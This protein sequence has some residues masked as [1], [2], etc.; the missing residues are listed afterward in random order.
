MNT[1]PARKGSALLIV[2]GMLSFMVVS[3]VA[4]SA[5]MRVA[6]LPSSYLRRTS[7]SRQ[8]VKAAVARAIDSVDRAIANNPH[9]GIGRDSIGGGNRNVW[10]HRIFT[11]T[12]AL[13]EADQTVPVLTLEALA[14]IPPPLVN[15]A[16]Y[17]SRKTPSAQWQSFGF[18]SGR[19]A[20][21]AIDV[22]DYFDVN[23][24][25][26]DSARSSASTRRVSLAY[27]FENGMDHAGTGT[28]AAQWDTFMETFRTVD[29]ETLE[30]K[31]GTKMPLVSVADLN[32]AIGQG[33]YGDL[34]SP[35]CKYV[36]GQG[37]AGFYNT[38]SE[39]DEDRIRRM[40]FVTDSWFPRN[41][42]AELKENDSE[43]AELLDLNAEDGQP[44][45]AQLLN[46]GGG[47]PR[48][49]G[50]STSILDIMA[51]GQKAKVRLL[52]GMPVMGLVS[53]YDYLDADNQP[54]SLACP[55]L[56]RT[57]MCCAIKPNFNGTLKLQPREDGPLVDDAGNAVN[58]GAAG[59]P[60]VVHQ[61]VTYRIDGSGLTGFAA[62]ANA[63]IAYP[64][65]HDDG[66]GATSFSIDG[67][68]S[69][70]FTI[71]GENMG[72]R[73]YEASDAEVL[74][75]AT[76]TALDDKGLSARGIV[77][78]PMRFNNGSATSFG[79]KNLTTEDEALKECPM[80]CREATGLGVEFAKF[81]LMTL[82]YKWTQ[83][84]NDDAGEYQP[85]N[86]PGD[87]ELEKA[88]CG[89]PPVAKDAA[90]NF[91]AADDSPT[92][93]GNVNF[94]AKLKNGI[95]VSMNVAL[96]VRVAENSKTV[97]LVPAHFNDDKTFN[98]IDNLRSIQPQAVCGKEFPLMRFDTGVRFTLSE[99]GVSGLDAGM[100]V[101]ISPSAV[102]VDDPRFNYAPENWHVAPDATKNA[103]LD[104]NC[105]A[106]RDGDIFMATSDQ[107]YLQSIYELAMLPRF[108]DLSSVGGAALTGS[109]KA[110]ADGRTTFG[111]SGT[112]VNEHLMWRTYNPFGANADDFEGLGFTS[113]GTGYKVNPY[114][115][116][117]NVMMA[118]F[119]NSPA[120]WRVAST[121]N[122]EQEF[123][124]MDA[125]EFNSKYAFNAFAPAGQRV[126]WQ[127]LAGIAGNFMDRI[128]PVTGR[129]NGGAN[130]TD[131]KTAWR[132]LGWDNADSDRIC[133][134]DLDGS[135]DDLWGVDRKFLYG[136]WRDC[137]EA[138]QQLF[139]IF[140]RAEPM[141]MGGGMVGQVPPQLG[142]RA[143]ALVWRDPRAVSAAASGPES[144]TG[145]PH[146]TR[147][148]FYR[149]LE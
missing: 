16:R 83:T 139:L 47:G 69:I 53:L 138:K 31:F 64:F 36:R 58:D 144:G 17:Y 142:A 55:S 52:D 65:A 145:Y 72:L 115:D 32:L 126:S 6:R 15:A 30:V 135:T 78:L 74:H 77:N 94:R 118:A 128:C 28:G 18:D 22:S 108:S 106:D 82:T 70:F 46:G 67:R 122:Q 7:A 119:A 68:A 113:S 112:A 35:F 124:T 98:N 19:Y 34:G 109:L 80:L 97:D 25:L 24:L 85:K 21:C 23:R 87:A 13:L 61:T 49:V 102:M 60:R 81:P 75:L 84:W 105:Y 136:Y 1:I 37:G 4:F 116:S 93:A 104:N 132:N 140:V 79:G 41:P 117:T 143:V 3:A 89:I 125:K 129:S 137:F 8:L 76:K 114:T 134:V 10:T 11:A 29:E 100:P 54:V 40:T 59:P 48:S 5:Y 56:E 86:R 62:G 123:E 121:N 63:L 39:Q 43:Y 90:N 88:H 131:W 99:A 57:P 45:T 146:Q 44:F 42:E 51:S 149:Q 95:A 133:G 96:W 91:Y 111:T 12:N 20:F 27:L 33:T 2:L 66:V 50:K 38:S 103:W 130:P 92:A 14:Y 110:P 101:A 107:G 147:T 73:T 9:P 148:L 141:M 120:G 26:A 71:D 127:T